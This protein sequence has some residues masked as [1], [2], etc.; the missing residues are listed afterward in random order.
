[1]AA[2]AAPPPVNP[3]AR[4]STNPLTTPQRLAI[5]GDW[6]GDTNWACQAAWHAHSRGADVLIHLGDFGY[7]FRPHFL[8]RLTET[9]TAAGLP[10]LFVDGNHDDHLWLARR[11][12]GRN[13]LRQLTDWVWHIP[14]GFRWRWG[15]LKFC[16]LG[17]AHSV[18]A[19][20]RRRGGLMWQPQ[21]RITE[22]QA[23]IVKGGGRCDVL[24]SHDCPAGV[25]I[26]GLHPGDFPAA[27]LLRAAEHRQLLREIVDV[28]QPR[29][30]WHGHYHQRY[31]QKVNFGF[32]PVKVCGLAENG[33]AIAGNLT[34]VDLT[35]LATDLATGMGA[36]N[37]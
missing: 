13:G 3:P 22:T 9:L 21:E 5:A 29:V 23:T 7:E 31:E 20:W 17:G 28:V 15:D 27:E 35:D 32:G 24:F 30:I 1:M 10:L 18:D 33:S 26:P 19:G 8:T 14:R 34:I 4:V 6:H 37:G 16:G 2:C 12:V 25:D 36:R 11:K